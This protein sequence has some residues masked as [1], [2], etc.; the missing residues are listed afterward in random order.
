MDLLAEAEA[1]LRAA[2]H[3]RWADNLR[4]HYLPAGAIEDK[5]TY[6]LVTTF[7]E[8]FLADLTGFETSIREDIVDGV[9]HV[10]ERQQQTR[11]RERAGWDPDD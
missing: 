8:G 9:E 7:R 6:E 1:D 10:S 3:D 2:G 11:W 4:D 5:W